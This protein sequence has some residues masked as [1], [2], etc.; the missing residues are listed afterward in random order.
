MPVQPFRR[1][2]GAAVLA[3]VL[4]CAQVST[5]SAREAEIVQ[6]LVLEQQDVVMWVSGPCDV[7]S[8]DLG[9]LYEQVWLTPGVFCKVSYPPVG[10]GEA[11][12][13]PPVPEV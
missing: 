5:S 2:V 10:W 11:P 1:L 3:V 4:V 7:Q 13:P 8:D 9:T 6:E 12:P